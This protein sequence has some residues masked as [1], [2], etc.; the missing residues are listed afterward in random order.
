VH[1]STEN[2]AADKMA[3]GMTKA[4]LRGALEKFE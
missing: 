2:I 3:V 4:L 1:D